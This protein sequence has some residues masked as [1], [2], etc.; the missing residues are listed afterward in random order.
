MLCYLLFFTVWSSHLL[1]FFYWDTVSSDRLKGSQIYLISALGITE[2]L[3]L[4][5]EQLNTPQLLTSG[6]LA[7]SLLSYCL[8]R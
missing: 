3:N 1:L 6:L 5:L 4:Y 2:H 8:D 7:V